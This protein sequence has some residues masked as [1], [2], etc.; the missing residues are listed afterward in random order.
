MSLRFSFS[1]ILLLAIVT[2]CG[3]PDPSTDAAALPVRF[4]AIDLQQMDTAESL[5]HCTPTLCANL[6]LRTSLVK[7][8]RRISIVEQLTASFK[9]S[10]AAQS[11]GSVRG[12]SGARCRCACA[13]TL[14][15]IG[16]DISL[17]PGVQSCSPNVSS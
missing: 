5:Q 8:H 2:A 17:S 7:P 4:V 14:A 12:Q 1:A 3:K 10:G 16:T 6:K 15:R 13:Q 11:L 9:V